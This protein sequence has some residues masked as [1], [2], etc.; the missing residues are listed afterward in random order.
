MRV[1]RLMKV[2]PGDLESTDSGP[3]V[4]G[5]TIAEGPRISRSQPTQEVGK[6]PGNSTA[7]VRAWQ[8]GVLRVWGPTG[9]LEGMRATSLGG[10]WDQSAKSTTPGAGAHDGCPPPGP[11]SPFSVWGGWLPHAASPQL[12]RPLASGLIEPW[13]APAGNLRMERERAVPQQF[14]RPQLGRGLCP[15]ICGHRRPLS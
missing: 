9:A 5:T 3:R 11:F 8:V 10:G 12:P 4:R 6:G 14:A 15:C 2:G 7:K 13:E 1:K